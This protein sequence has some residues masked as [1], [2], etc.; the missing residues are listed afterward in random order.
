MPHEATT[1]HLQITSG[2]QE[3]VAGLEVSVQHIGRVDVLEASQ[4]LV[5]E[6]ANMI[7]A[8]VLSF[9]QFVQVS[10]HQCLHNVAGLLSGKLPYFFSLPS[11]N[12]L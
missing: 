2:V 8:Q 12:A 11:H 10:L 4:D 6:V 1:M 3:E 9:E 5:E 7:V